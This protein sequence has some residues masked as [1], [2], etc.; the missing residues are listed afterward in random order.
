[1]R[2]VHII[3]GVAALLL[4]ACQP[5]DTPTPS[6][7]TIAP[8]STE[9][10]TTPTISPTPPP[11]SD[12]T[13]SP[14]NTI[15]ATLIEVPGAELPPGFSLIKFTDFYRPTSL[16]FDDEG[17]LYATSFDGTAHLLSDV[18][19]NGR[20]DRDV[21][22]AKG[23][24][25]PLGITIAPGT[26]DVYISSK[27][28]ITLVQDSNEDGVPN[29]S[30]VWMDDLPASGRHQNDNLKFGPDGWLYVGI[31]STC[32]ACEEVNPLSATIVRIDPSTKQREIIATGLRNPYDLAFDP[33]TG[34]LF[35]TDNGRDDLGVEEPHEELNQIVPDG[36]YGWPKCWD[37]DQ[38]S[39]C[40]TSIPPIAMFEPRSSVN[41][42]VFYEGGNFPAE[43]QG[44][45]YASVF[46]SWERDV[47]R[48]I[49]RVKLTPNGDAY[50]TKTEW[51]VKWPNGWLLGMAVGPD[52]ALYVGDYINGGIYRIS[53][54]L[55]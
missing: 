3:A 52:G 24:D 32:D 45:L 34:A 7:V 30:Q 39:G 38:G 51:F 27:G 48:G 2:R 50:T 31:G 42:L 25:T 43:Y 17:R 26:H 1:M 29:S 21:S 33:E 6:S 5:I 35:A 20:T 44:S 36:F 46:G 22:F 23:F 55:P 9:R 10:L 8:T 54:G 49:W 37:A 18:D 19:K 16:A 47:Q 13:G 28:K 4:M 41:S 14:V 11:T 12:G 53:Y 40:D 15:P